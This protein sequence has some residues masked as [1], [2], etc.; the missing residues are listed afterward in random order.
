MILAVC[1]PDLHNERTPEN[2]FGYSLPSPVS[3]TLDEAWK[4]KR[5]AT[6]VGVKT[7][8]VRIAQGPSG[9]TVLS[10]TVSD[11]LSAEITLERP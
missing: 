3:V 6:R 9:K 2:P 10:A 11:G 8:E 1:D 5:V 4:V 7:P